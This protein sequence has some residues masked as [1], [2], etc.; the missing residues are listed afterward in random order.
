MYWLLSGAYALFANTKKYRL[1]PKGEEDIKN[2]PSRSEVIKIV[3]LQQSIQ[4]SVNLIL[5]MFISDNSDAIKPEPPF[6]VRLIQFISAMTSEPVCEEQTSP[7]LQISSPVPVL[8]TDIYSGLNLLL[9]NTS[10]C[11]DSMYFF[12][13]GL[14][15]LLGQLTLLTSVDSR[16]AG[17][18]EKLLMPNIMTN[19]YDYHPLVS[20]VVS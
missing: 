17:S 6:F 20:R 5:F 4:I 8:S 13:N 14:L 11:S 1:H 10:I 19:D 7:E 9:W 12:Q 3:L 18:L 16:L 15:T 2:I